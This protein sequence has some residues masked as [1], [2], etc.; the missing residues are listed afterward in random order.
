MHCAILQ[1]HTHRDDDNEKHC[2]QYDIEL[3]YN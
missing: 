1:I 2:T 3:I